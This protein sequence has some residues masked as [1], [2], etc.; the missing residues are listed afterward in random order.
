MHR[1]AFLQHATAGMM[2]L[3]LAGPPT[4]RKPRYRRAG[5]LVMIDL[6]GPSLDAHTR[7]LIRRHRI[8][9]VVLLQRNLVDRVQAVQLIQELRR[10]MGVGA[11]IAIDQEGGSVVRTRD[12][13]FPPSAMSLGASNDPELAFQ[14]GA[15][16]GRAL[17]SLGVNW[18]FAP[19]LDVNSNPLNPVIGDRSFGADPVRVSRLGLAWAQGCM[20][21]GVAACVKHFPGHGDTH[22]DSHLGLPT[23]DKPREHLDQTELAPFREAAQ[24]GLPGFM[25]GHLVFP[26][27]DP[28]WPATLSP[29]ILHDLLRTTW[30]FEGVVITDAMDMQAM[31]RNYGRAESTRRAIGAG[32]D[33][34]L[35]MG[36]PEEQDTTLRAL[37]EAL[38]QGDIPSTRRGHSLDRLDRL[39]RHF[40][41]Q[42]HPYPED[43]Q[44]ADAALMRDAWWRGFTPYRHPQPPPRGSRV[45]LL[46]PDGPEGGGASDPTRAGLALRDLMQ[47][48]YDLIPVLY[49]R[50][51]PQDR[52]AAVQEIDRTTTLVVFASTGRLRPGEDLKALIAAARPDLHLA[53]WNPYAVLD[54][55][56]PA[57]ITYGLRPEALEGVGAW[58]DGTLAPRGEAPIP[59]E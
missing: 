13:P 33:L 56:A 12:F 46:A 47:S 44:A 3:W 8:R 5:P 14:V 54:V 2:G 10:R 19:V 36:K 38:R 30:G 59:L 43:Q 21:A 50:T 23:V 1:R 11:I 32:A 17:A 20:S 53:L 18:N 9:A 28:R 16:T 7:D 15:A 37:D 35:A 48:R 51:R 57:L 25:T 27:L 42:P 45:V 31:T 41:S 4:P 58:L 49:S 22:E 29:P 24:A 34:V 40:P 52:L 55:P 6:P 39:T 26:S